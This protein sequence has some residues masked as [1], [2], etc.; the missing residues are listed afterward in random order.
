MSAFFDFQQFQRNLFKQT[1]PDI[2]E[3]APGQKDEVEVKQKK[4]TINLI[5]TIERK[6]RKVA[7]PRSK[8]KAQTTKKITPEVITKAAPV[9]ASQSTDKISP[10]IATTKSVEIAIS[11]QTTPKG[12]GK[13]KAANKR[14]SVDEDYDFGNERKITKSTENPYSR[15][16]NNSGSKR[17]PTII[18]M[19]KLDLLKKTQEESMN[20]SNTRQSLR[21]KKR[22][23]ADVI[24][25]IVEDLS[26]ATDQEAFLYR[27]GLCAVVP[28]GI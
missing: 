17:P 19:T 11:K 16:F 22:N 8:V 7:T 20:S 28:T 9:L 4:P 12:R 25:E 5:G 6:P 26:W 13:A 15:S 3:R 18:Q 10:I 21:C 24:I 23:S 14:R 27:L 1:M 2:Y